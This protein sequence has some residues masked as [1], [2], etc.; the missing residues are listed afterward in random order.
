MFTT[1]LTAAALKFSVSAIC[2]GLS[3]VFTAAQAGTIVRVS[4]PAIKGEVINAVTREPVPHAVVNASWE[5]EPENDDSSATD[6]RLTVQQV[7]T[8]DNGEFVI[9]GWS[10]GRRVPDGW[11]LKAGHDPKISV[12][13]NG[14][15]HGEFENQKA[16]K[17]NKS[18]AVNARN[19]KVLRSAWNSAKLLLHPFSD[20]SGRGMYAGPQWSA[21]LRTWLYGIQSEIAAYEWR[22]KNRARLSQMRLMDLLN[23]N[24]EVI[25]EIETESVCNQINS[26]P[27]RKN[28]KTVSTQNDHK[29]TTTLSVQ[30]ENAETAQSITQNPSMSAQEISPR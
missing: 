11:R 27:N 23:Q 7:T 3:A 12:Y 28:S 30:K 18:V 2:I 6:R 4:A 8:D 19:A 16:G 25:K 10:A 20:Y 24:C 14:F 22:N 26:N 5:I 17:N 9:P 1:K 29:P 15:Y 13:A 21:E